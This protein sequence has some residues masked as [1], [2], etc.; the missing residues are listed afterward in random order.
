LRG[1]EIPK[2]ELTGVIIYFSD[3]ATTNPPHVNLSLIGRFKQEEGEKQHILPVE[4][5]TVSG[6]RLRKWMERLLS[7]KKAAGLTT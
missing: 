2:I 7:E 1:G 6:L 4:V 3:G 5:V